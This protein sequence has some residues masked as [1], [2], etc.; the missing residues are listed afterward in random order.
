MFIRKLKLYKFNFK[1]IVKHRWYNLRRSRFRSTHRETKLG[2]WF[3]PTR[4]VRTGNLS[5][6]SKWSDNLVL[7]IMLGMNL[8]IITAWIEFNYQ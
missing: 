2:V 3:K 8:L 5:D 6:I 7:N 4:I 1:F